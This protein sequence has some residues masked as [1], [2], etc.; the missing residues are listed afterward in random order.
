MKR[1]VILTALSLGM[2]QLSAQTDFET[3]KRQQQ[4]KFSAYTKQQREEF[5]AYRA[6]L[7]AEYAEFMSKA[8]TACSASAAKP[9]PKSTEP[10]KPATVDP[11]QTEG[12]EFLKEALPI[13]KILASKKP[14]PPVVPA[15]PLPEVKPVVQSSPGH[16]FKF[17]GTR[18][19]VGLTEA[20]RFTLKSSKERDAA[21]GWKTLAHERYIDI[22]AQCMKHREALRL[23]D[24]GY[25]RFLQEMTGSFFTADHSNEAVLMQM[26]ILVQSGYKVRVARV[27]DKLVLLLPMTNDIYNYSYIAMKDGHYYIIAKI[28]AGD[29]IYVYDRKFPQEQPFSL[30]MDEVPLLTNDETELRTL[31]SRKSLS[32]TVATNYNLIDYYND[33]PKSSE[34]NYYSIASL[35]PDMKCALYPPLRRAIAGKSKAEAANLLLDFVQ[36]SLEYQTDDEQFGGERAFFADETLFYPY[37]DCEDRSILYSILVRDLL[38]LDVVL[39]H[40]PGHLATAV[41]FDEEVS[42]DHLL[43]DG[44]KYLVC[45]P[46]YIGA[47]IG[48]AIPKYRKTSVNVVR[49]R[50]SLTLP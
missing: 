38:G 34:W 23:C 21:D 4:Q 14:A 40:Y 48:M 39:L 24:W 30:L 31:T 27:N 12:L 36:T 8:W 47:D 43:I 13:G 17:Y 37:C 19:R 6:K 29:E 11:T 1:I 15:I 9:M 2:S 26:Y 49:I 18:C 20:H 35:S 45:D 22:V 10:V 32:A 44:V 46:T 7:N 28:E 41:C 42:G 16:T 5:E 33:Y 3:Y 50:P 25:V